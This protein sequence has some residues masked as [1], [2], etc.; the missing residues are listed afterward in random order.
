MELEDSFYGRITS[1]EGG[2]L[3]GLSARMLEVCGGLMTFPLAPLQQFG[4]IHVPINH[5]FVEK[6]LIPHFRHFAQSYIG[7]KETNLQQLQAVLEVQPNAQLQKEIQ[8][9]EDG[10]VS[11]HVNYSVLTS[12]IHNAIRNKTLER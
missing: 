6:D 7:N 2:P 5:T 10:K 11:R 9:L 12:F 1:K 3:L 8:E 4:R